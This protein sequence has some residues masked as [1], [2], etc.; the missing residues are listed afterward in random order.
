GS[1]KSEGRPIAAD[2][3]AVGEAADRRL[4][5]RYASERWFRRAGL[6]AISFSLLA[7]GALHGSIVLDALATFRPHSV[8]LTVEL[9]AGQLDPYG[10]R[11]EESLAV[12]NAAAV[13]RSALS[14]AIPEA[15]SRADRRALGELLSVGAEYDL[16]DLVK[17]NPELL[18]RSQEFRALLSDD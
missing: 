9:D 18:G 8:R 10:D 5:R 15:T 3:G 7:L 12:G 4:R 16:L 6:A 14:A 11:S 1:S 17:S 2:G 13:L